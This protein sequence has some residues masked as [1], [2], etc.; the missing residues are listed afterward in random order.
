MT[1]HYGMFLAWWLL[2][3]QPALGLLLGLW[4]WP[5]LFNALDGDSQP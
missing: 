1:D 2:F 5:H 4:L 3:G